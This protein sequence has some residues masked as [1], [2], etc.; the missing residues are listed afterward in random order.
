MILMVSVQNLKEAY[1]A[2]KGG[3]DIVDVKNLQEALV[4]SAKPNIFKDVRK[5]V[6]A[7]IHA[8]LTLGVV[9][10]QEGTVAMAVWAAGQMKAT[11]VKV[12]FMQADYDKSV[13]VLQASKEA[14]EG[15]ETKL[16]GS[17][18]ADNVL[19][20]GGLDPHLM[21]KL[22]RDGK[23]DGWL[24]DTLT[25]DG[26]NLFDFLSEVELRDIVM[27]GKSDGMSTALSG[28]LKMSDLD[29]LTRVNPDIV[30]VRGAVCSKGDRDNGVYSESVAEFKRQVELRKSGDIEVLEDI[31]VLNKNINESNGWK[32]IDGTGKTCAGIIAALSQE[33]NNKSD[34]FIEVVIPDVLN[35]YDILMWVEKEKHSI[36]TQRKDE[37]GFVRILISP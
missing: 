2:M 26:R 24:I 14:L 6:P 37:K 27:E 33:I 4:G 1:E 12:G 8:S 31:S 15:T 18:F 17:L 34:S 13:E 35:T 10:N 7:D 23:C 21:P 19:Y 28:H 29:E 25:K 36:L 30:G 5:A 11:S 9:P 20:D 32:V 16:I 3:A 22:A